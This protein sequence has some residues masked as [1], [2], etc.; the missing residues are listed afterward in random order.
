MAETMIY[1]TEKMLKEHGE[2]AKPEDKKDVEEKLEALK[3]IKDGDDFEAIKKA[4]DELATAAQKIGA[5]M[6]EQQKSE[7]AQKPGAE[8]QA[9][10][11]GA[12]TNG[13]EAEQK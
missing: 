4:G 5:A 12:E 3:K 10:E 2:K 6:Y 8:G 1:T 7:E 9:N 11:S 13:P